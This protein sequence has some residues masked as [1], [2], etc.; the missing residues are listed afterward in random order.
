MKHIYFM[1]LNGVETG[2]EDAGEHGGKERLSLLPGHTAPFFH[3]LW[4]QRSVRKSDIREGMQHMQEKKT[5]RKNTW[6]IMQR[7]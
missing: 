4:V 7:K 2:A 1:V 3:V 6:A 5:W